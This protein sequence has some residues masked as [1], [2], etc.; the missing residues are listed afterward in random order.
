METGTTGQGWVDGILVFIVIKKKKKLQPFNMRKCPNFPL[1]G[2]LHTSR[3]T[4][5]YGTNKTIAC[6]DSTQTFP[7]R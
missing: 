4:G 7:K 6:R 5:F 2:H 1:V 3:A